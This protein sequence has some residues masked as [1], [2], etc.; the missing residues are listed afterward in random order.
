MK[1]TGTG[2]PRAGEP[3]A[4]VERP[5]R[6]DSPGGAEGLERLV[7]RYGLD[8]PA[9]GRLAALLDRLSTDE[10]AP[11]AV[12]GWEQVLDRHIADS[13]AGLELAEV[14][15]ALRIA[16]L[17]AGAGLPGLVLA[18]AIPAAEVR[19]VESQQS[20]C[21]YIASLAASAGLSNARVVCARVEEWADGA[22]DQDLVVARA[23]APQPVVLEY[24]AP[25]LEIG[26]HLVEW[27]GRR[28]PDEEAR[29]DAAA[30]QLGLA[31]AEVRHVT[32]F[33]GAEDRHLHVFVKERATPAGFPRRVGLAGKRPL[34]A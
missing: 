6:V 10:R 18:A 23:L 32:P 26:A 5:I 13:L 27:R 11:T 16:D 14:R 12:R 4:P 9:Q 29:A 20:K 31:R 28:D 8:T 21:A 30:A 25:L 2:L 15:S 3:Q 24:A 33:P 7:R 19:T 22:E 1:R 17:G 34:G